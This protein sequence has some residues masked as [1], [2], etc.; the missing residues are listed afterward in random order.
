MQEKRRADSGTAMPDKRLHRGPHPEDAAVFAA[1]ALARLAGA[2]ADFCW[3]LSRGYAP[4]STIQLV[5]DRYALTER[6][7]IAVRRCACSDQALA[8]RRAREFAPEQ[9]AGQRLLLDGYN[10]LTTVEAAL[11]G[12]VVLAGRD[13]CF[14]DMASMHGSFKTVLET[15]PAIELIGRTLARFGVRECVWYLDRPVSNSGRLKA[16]IVQTARE[17]GW[18]WTVELVQNPDAILSAAPEIVASADSAVLDECRRW[19]NLARETVREHAGRAWV[20][21][22]ARGA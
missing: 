2:T 18:N 14:R 17:H 6:Q 1:G 16:L 13:G 5:G 9:V 22:F 19:F 21:D 8:G 15:A 7:R 12:G 10:V 20:V 3:L 11:A 4:H